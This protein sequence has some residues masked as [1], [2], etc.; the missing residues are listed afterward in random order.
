VEVAEV[1]AQVLEK[2]LDK[3]DAYRML[4]SLSGEIFLK[5]E[6]PVYLVSLLKM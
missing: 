2:P 3:D 6:L 5:H 4:S 1:Q